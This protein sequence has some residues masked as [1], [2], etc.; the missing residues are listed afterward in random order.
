MLCLKTCSELPSLCITCGGPLLWCEIKAK[1]KSINVST[2]WLWL[3]Q[4]ST[5]ALLSFSS[6]FLKCFCLLFCSLIGWMEFIP[7]GSLIFS[8]FYKTQV[9]QKKVA[10]WEIE[11]QLS[12]NCVCLYQPWPWQM[13]NF[14]RLWKGPVT[15]S[16]PLKSWARGGKR[17]R[18]GE[19]RGVSHRWEEL[20][21]W[22]GATR[23]QQQQGRRKLSERKGRGQIRNL[24]L[25]RSGCVVS[26]V[27][28]WG[29]WALGVE[30]VSQEEDGRGWWEKEK[31]Y[32]AVILVWLITGNKPGCARCM[33][34]ASQSPHPKTLT[35]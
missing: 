7:A 2:R 27:S 19:I 22:E 5:M 12:W 10:A 17:E 13:R 28:V 14:L 15:Q 32:P 30:C 8:P 20:G 9:G 3:C 11:N 6:Y 25:L 33:Y 23:Q 31:G 21:G 1:Q 34:A 29:R 18:R 4:A 24:I 16:V 26:V 35:D